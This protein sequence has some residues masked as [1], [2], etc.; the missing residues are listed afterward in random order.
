MNETLNKEKIGMGSKAI[1]AAVESACSRIAPTWPLESFIAVSPWWGYANMRIEETAAR[2]EALAG[3]RMLMPPDWYRQRLAAGDISPATAAAC[4]RRRGV[5]SAAAL[6]ADAALPAGLLLVPDAIDAGRDLERNLSCRSVVTNAVS[7]LCAAWF[8]RGQARWGAGSGAL[9]G[10]SLYAHWR[11]T[12]ARDHGPEM[13][14]GMRGIAAAIA[15]LPADPRATI[16]E[17]TMRLELP[18]AALESYFS[19]LL[20]TQ[21]GWAAWCAQLDR[22]RC[23]HE[24]APSHLEQLL[25]MLLGWDM[26]LHHHADVAARNL[27]RARLARM[28]VNATPAAAPLWALQDALERDYQTRLG[29]RLA[30]GRLQHQEAPALQAAFC[31]DVRSENLRRALEACDARIQTLGFAGFFGLPADYLPLGATQAQAQLPG[32]LK[33]SMRIAEDEPDGSAAPIAQSR[34]RRLGWLRTWES[35]RGDAIS[36]FGLVETLGLS[37]AGKLLRE[38]MGLA[39]PDRPEA[40]GLSRDERDRIRPRLSGLA[41]EQAVS[42][43]AGVLRG[44]SLTRDFAPV[45]LLVGHASSSRNNAHAAGLDCGA[46]C[47]HSGEVNARALAALL[48]EAE[49]RQGL[50]ALGIVIPAATRFIAGLHDTTTDEVTLFDADDEDLGTVQRW[51]QEASSAA[52]T[53]RAPAL[54]GLDADAHASVRAQ[55]RRRSRDWSEIR[56]EWGLANNA[57]FLIAPRARSRNAELEGRAFLHDYRHEA[58]PDAVVLEAIMAG[59]LIVAHWINMQ[60][61]ASV[62]DNRRWGSG[63]KLLHNVVGAGIGVFEGNGGDLRIGLPLQSLHDGQDWRHAPQRLCAWIEAPREAI[64]SV[65]ARQPRLRQLLE[66]GWMHLLRIDPDD[67]SRWRLDFDGGGVEWMALD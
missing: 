36:G 62:V 61:Y 14:L 45:V 19:A 32:I 21:N 9:E 34:Q 5:D 47:G 54:P 57:A 4:A 31:I 27:W 65:L 59:P 44:M 22:E 33:P 67:G 43:A 58:D 49:L 16:A 30:A 25:A 28:P 15:T 53:R 35:W 56:P 55:L 38:A 2:M 13:L 50:S 23:G 10:E 46:C 7:Q 63:N 3:S 66:G 1:H 41:P 42:L 12:G 6:N 17:A 52:C 8:D 11:H 26:V 37:H 20:L 18:Q 48:N 51:L 39:P 60:Y 24:T 29:A 64:E 40:C